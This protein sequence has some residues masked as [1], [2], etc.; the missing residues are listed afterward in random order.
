MYG[1]YTELG[2]LPEAVVKRLRHYFLTYKNLPEEPAVMELANIYGQAEAWEV[3][4][5]SINDYKLM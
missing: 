4:Q 3:I 1:Q 5:T 2:Q